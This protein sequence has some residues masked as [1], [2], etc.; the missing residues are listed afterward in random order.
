MITI[1]AELNENDCLT[2]SMK[3]NKLNPVAFAC[4]IGEIVKEASKVYHME[5]DD[6]IE[7]LNFV[8]KENDDESAD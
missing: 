4:V 2:I 3:G 7:L 5:L 8:I 1:K 6:F